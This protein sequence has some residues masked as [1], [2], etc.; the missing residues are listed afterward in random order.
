MTAIENPTPKLTPKDLF[1]AQEATREDVRRLH[2]LLTLLDEPT[3][4]NDSLDQITGVLSS[5]V[6]ILDRHG[7]TL[8]EIKAAVAPDGTTAPQ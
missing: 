2:P 4:G 7:R 5:I 3:D 8:D 6:S 1:Q